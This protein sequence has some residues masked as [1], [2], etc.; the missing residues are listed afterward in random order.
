MAKNGLQRLP[1]LGHLAKK[2]LGQCPI[3][4]PSV[5]YLGQDT[6]CP[7]SQQP[8]ARTPTAIRK[9]HPLPIPFLAPLSLADSGH[10]PA[11][12][13]AAAHRHGFPTTFRIDSPPSPAVPDTLLASPR[14]PGGCRTRRLQE[15]EVGRP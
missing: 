9:F 14:A 7:I 13:R 2:I 4:G 6:H 12:S 3:F 15:T 5:V 10:N 1:Y 8:R 11:K